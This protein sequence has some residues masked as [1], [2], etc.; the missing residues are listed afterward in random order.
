MHTLLKKKKRKYETIR[1]IELFLTFRYQA[2][3]CFR[4]MSNLRTAQLAQYGQE[5]TRIVAIFVSIY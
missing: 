1:I 5:K 2:R 3:Q 4:K